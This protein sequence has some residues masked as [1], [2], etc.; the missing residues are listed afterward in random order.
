MSVDVRGALAHLGRIVAAEKKQ[1]NFATKVAL[2]RTGQKVMVAEQREMRDVFSMPTPF[3]MSSLYLRPATSSNLSAEVKLK[4]FASKATPASKFLAAQL[5]GGERVQKRFERALQAVGALP[6]GFRI[7]PGDA[8]KLDAYGNM[9]RGQIVQILAFFRAFPEAGYKA[10]MTAQG[11]AK[12]AR[13]GK[14]RQGISYFAGRPGDRLPLGIYQRVTFARG[15]AIKPVMI[16]VRSAVYQA[17]F[18]F[19]DV[20]K[21]TVDAEF[22]PQ[23]AL[24]YAEAKRTAR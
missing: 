12:L 23:F 20:A 13:G 9:D 14:T 15:T 10:N 6:P 11:R 4:D 2:T 3:T 16:F 22:G 18:N 1:V 19:E 17:V 7:V 8:A 24:A 5:K 21:R